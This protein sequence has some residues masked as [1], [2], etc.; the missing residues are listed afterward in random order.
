[1]SHLDTLQVRVDASYGQVPVDE[2][3]RVR[4]A[5]A[6]QRKDAEGAPKTF[7]ETWQIYGAD[8]GVVTVVYVGSCTICKLNLEFTEDHEIPGL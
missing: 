5:L 8:E 1:M 7:R 4:A 3:D 6:Q 2:F